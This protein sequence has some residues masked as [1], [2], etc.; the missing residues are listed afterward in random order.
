ML[1][2]TVRGTARLENTGYDIVNQLRRN[3]L[4]SSRSFSKG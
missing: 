4:A 3:Q 2:S 1:G